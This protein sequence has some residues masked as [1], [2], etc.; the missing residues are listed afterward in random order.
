MRDVFATIEANRSGGRL[1]L[2]REGAS[3]RGGGRTRKLQKANHSLCYCGGPQRHPLRTR[4]E[5]V[6][7]R[8]PL[9]RPRHGAIP[10]ESLALVY[11]AA[12]EVSSERFHER[13]R[14]AAQAA[15]RRF[16]LHSSARMIRDMFRSTSS[17]SRRIACALRLAQPADRLRIR[18][19][20]GATYGLSA[21]RRTQRDR[22][23]QRW[24]QNFGQGCKWISAGAI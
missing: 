7:P 12:G 10:C 19:R 20:P 16:A 2:L 14:P 5:G 22:Q 17:T 15:A 3:R 24:P 4:P 9:P 13:R 8:A 23:K 11:G 6:P 18:R 21:T 1:R